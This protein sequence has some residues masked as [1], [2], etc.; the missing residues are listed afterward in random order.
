MGCG[1]DL[2]MGPMGAVIQQNF[3]PRPAAPPAPSFP[4]R[5]PGKGL[6]QPGW[7]GGGIGPCPPLTADPAAVA[8]GLQRALA[9]W[10]WA[11]PPRRPEQGCADAV[12]ILKE[13]RAASVPRPTNCNGTPLNCNGRTHR[14]VPAGTAGLVG[15]AGAH[16]LES[17][18]AVKLQRGGG[19]P[20][21]PC[22]GLRAA[23]LLCG[24]EQQSR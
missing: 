7:Q 17:A 12:A 10:H 21:V 23:E 5:S 22:P 9:R 20:Q 6:G 24:E 16:H 15:T 3:S 19:T 14:G 18:I 1:W 11:L 13:S 4:P 2:R 8:K